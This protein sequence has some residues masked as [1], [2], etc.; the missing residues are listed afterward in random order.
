[1][2]SAEAGLRE[3][4]AH[5]ELWIYDSLKCEC[6]ANDGQNDLLSHVTD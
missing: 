6:P 2:A 1:M 4:A 3:Q 5:L